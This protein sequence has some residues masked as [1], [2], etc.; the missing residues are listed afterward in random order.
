MAAL[1]VTIDKGLKTTVESE[2]YTWH[3]DELVENGG[4]GVA[5]DPVEQL[6][7]SVGSCMAITVQL[8]A[9]R[10]QWPLEKIEIQLHLERFKA[11]QYPAYKGDAQFVTE[12][13]EH[14]TLFGDQLTEEQ[15][16]RLLEISTKCPVRRVL[17]NPTFF[18][19]SHGEAVT[20]T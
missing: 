11:D 19:E 5:A 17:M 10:K 1:T 4:T 7:G 12:I 9:Q 20:G 13:R 15:R 3:A 14:I 6:L 2:H 18:V 8:Y 16:T